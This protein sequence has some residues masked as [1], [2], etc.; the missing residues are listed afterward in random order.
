VTANRDEIRRQLRTA[1]TE[2]REA[3]PRFTRALRRAT[4]PD[5]DTLAAEQAALLGVPHSRRGFLRLGGITVAASAVLV[6]CGSSESGTEITR[7]GPTPKPSSATI[8]SLEPSDDLNVTLL[9]TAGSL[10][11]LAIATYQAALDGNWL[12]S[13]TLNEVA[14]LFRDQHQEH[15]DT[16]SA[17]TRALGE[18]PYTEPN[19]FLFD[20]VV[21]PAAE[22]IAA[23][24]SQDQ[25]LATLELAYTLEDVAAQT[26]TSAGGLFSTSELR[27]AGMSIGAVEARHISV[28]LSAL[29]EPAVPFAFGRTVNAVDEAAFI[30]TDGPVT[31]SEPDAEPA[32]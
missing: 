3:M 5:S 23:L 25:Q 8:P 12:R 28:I 31:P 30:T 21:G 27:Q 26:Y 22:S 11:A 9:L 19:P 17:A 32:G 10:E 14:R 7:T 24:E 13:A 6:A 15:L 20:N 29:E 4:D 16:V 2:Q 1:R 18:T